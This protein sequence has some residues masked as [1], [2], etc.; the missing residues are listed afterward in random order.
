MADGIQISELPAA[1]VPL[2]GTEL[3]PLVTVGAISG[4]TQAAS[5][6]ITVSNPVPT[7][8]FSV[9]ETVSITGVSGMTQINGLS[10]A[11][12][13]IG[14]VAGAWTITL[15]I[16][17]STFSAYSSGGLLQATATATIFEM[18][19]SAGQPFNATFASGNVQYAG[20]NG[21]LAGDN[22][23]IFGLSLPNP[24]GFNGPCLLSGSG[25]GGGSAITFCYISD[26]A[27]DN[28][29]PG[30]IVIHTSG[31]TQPAGTADG[32]L[33][34]ALGGASFGGTGGEI[35]IQAGTSANAAGGRTVLKGGAATGSTPAATAGDIFVEAGDE[36]QS[37]AIVHLIMTELNGVAGVIRHRVNSTILYDESALGEWEFTVSGVGAAGAAL[38]S[39]GPGQPVGWTTGYYTGAKVIG[40]Q[41]YTWNNGQL[42]SIV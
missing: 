19:L 29:T 34:W 11:V 15:P 6:I 3:V 40:G 38:V 41:T 30:N 28:T 10:A 36:G 12:S 18:R 4:I 14:G 8:P 17:S 22:N 25:G 20:P 23:L 21:L 26:Q 27:F 24:S 7:N 2:T 35:R 9:A 33:W 32:G 5:A 16:N 42:L 1:P 37:G 39:G 31:E 13:A